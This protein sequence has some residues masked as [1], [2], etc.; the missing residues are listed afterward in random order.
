M[1]DKIASCKVGQIVFGF[2]YPRADIVCVVP[3]TVLEVTEDVGGELQIET[4]EA[5]YSLSDFGQTVFLT[6]AEAETALQ[7]KER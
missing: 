7:R 5:F 1:K 3:E 2:A 6:Q 4:D